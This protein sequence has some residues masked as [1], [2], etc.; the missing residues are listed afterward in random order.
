MTH[1]GTHRSR[2]WLGMMGACIVGGMGIGLVRLAQAA[3][4]SGAASTPMIDDA[5]FNQAVELDQYR[6]GKVSLTI[7]TMLKNVSTILHDD[8]KKMLAEIVK[9]EAAVAQLNA[10]VAA[11]RHDVVGHSAAGHASS[12][13]TRSGS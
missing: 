5:A 6:E 3:Y 7:F 4:V 8:H 9:L 2:F 1:A 11:L 13:T 12:E 10:S